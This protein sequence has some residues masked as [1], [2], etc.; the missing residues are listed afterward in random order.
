MLTVFQ[1]PVLFIYFILHREKYQCEREKSIG[2]FPHA[3]Q[4]GL[5]PQPGYVAWLRI[6]PSTFGA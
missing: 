5:N 2:S 3:L 4:Q 6:K 1:G